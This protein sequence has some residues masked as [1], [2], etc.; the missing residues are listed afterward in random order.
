MKK[1][2]LLNLGLI[3]FTISL[4]AQQKSIYQKQVIATSTPEKNKVNSSSI[5]ASESIPSSSKTIFLNK[6]KKLD[7][8]LKS[9]LKA[10]S[11]QE[12]VDSRDIKKVPA[13]KADVD[14]RATTY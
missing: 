9:D 1:L 5:V 14:P 11:I 6:A 4:R 12:K 8:V 10:V 2:L 13:L 3:C 7:T